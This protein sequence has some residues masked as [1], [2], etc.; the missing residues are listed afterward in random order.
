MKVGDTVKIEGDNMILSV[1]KQ[2]KIISISE[3]FADVLVGDES[4]LSFTLSVSLNHLTVIPRGE[5]KEI[6]HE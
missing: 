5:Q 2:G 6:S 4:I 1:M 3:K